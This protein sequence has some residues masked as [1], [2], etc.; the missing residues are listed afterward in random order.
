[1]L[2]NPLSVSVTWLSAMWQSE[3]LWAHVKHSQLDSISRHF[4]HRLHC[5]SRRSGRVWPVSLLPF[6]QQA[7][8]ACGQLCRPQ[9][10]RLPFVVENRK[11][12]PSLRLE[13]AKKKIIDCYLAVTQAGAL[14]KNNQ[15]NAFSNANHFSYPAVCRA[16]QFPCHRAVPSL[17]RSASQVQLQQLRI[18]SAF[19]VK[20]ELTRTDKCACL[21]VFFFK[22]FS[23][24]HSNFKAAVIIRLCWGDSKWK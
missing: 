6:Y 22:R 12:V 11:Q 7:Q 9:G 14:K 3:S 21:N 5:E 13:A 8:A 17:V 16:A 20:R 10:T 4:I 15:A 23:L 19:Y 18:C 24:S 1:M 2:V